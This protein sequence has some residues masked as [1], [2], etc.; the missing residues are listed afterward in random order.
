MIIYS[1]K[2][3]KVSLKGN[4][5]S[6]ERV[7]YNSL[8]DS[9]SKDFLHQ[10]I[11][12][13]SSDKKDYDFIRVDQMKVRRNIKEIDLK[14]MTEPAEIESKVMFIIN[15][16]EIIYIVR[17]EEGELGLYEFCEGEGK[18]VLSEF[19]IKNSKSEEVLELYQIKYL[20]KTL[21]WIRVSKNYWVY[22]ET[23][24]KVFKAVSFINQKNLS[25]LIFELSEKGEPIMR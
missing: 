20:P 8:V 5:L 6:K 18:E 22:D 23:D 2:A 19:I 25:P 7:Y 15:E 4:V 17:E 11:S 24:N 3:Q 21:F 10:T 14:L 9:L 12:G 16:G 13:I 1:C